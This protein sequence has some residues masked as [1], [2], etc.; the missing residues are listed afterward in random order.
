MIFFDFYALAK[1][2]LYLIFIGRLF[3]PHYE[4]IYRYSK[5]IQCFLWMI[6]IVFSINTIMCSIRDVLPDALPLPDRFI[7]TYYLLLYNCTDTILS[8]CSTVLFFVPICCRR[9]GNLFSADVSKPV[10][11]KYGIIS[12]LQLIS[13]VLYQSWFLIFLGETLNF[14]T[15]F[16]HIM[17]LVEMLDCLLLMICIYVGFAV[18]TTV[19]SFLYIRFEF[20]NI[21]CGS[22]EQRLC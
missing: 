7:E 6:L 13:T 12:V 11:M 4:R 14:W 17:S 3:N 21:P 10:V 16:E 2:F 20:W 15:S 8:V 18:K 19:C 1:F 5:C 22:F 9:T